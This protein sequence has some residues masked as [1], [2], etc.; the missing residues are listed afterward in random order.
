MVE[1]YS[2]AIRRLDGQRLTV[3]VNEPLN[4]E[5]LQTLYYDYDGAKEIELRFVDPR[6]FT[7][8]QRNFIFALIGDIYSYTGQPT[9]DLT[10]YFK[11]KFNGATGRKISLADNSKNTMSDATQYANLILDF[12]FENGIPFRNGYKILPFN[13]SYFFYKCIVHRVCCSCGK[14]HAHIHHVDVVGMGNNRNKIDNRNRRFMA[15]CGECHQLIHE[16]GYQEFT[17]KRELYA[18]KLDEVALKRLGLHFEEE[19]KTNG[20][21]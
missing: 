15:L 5:R 20:R 8:E 10:E 14:L 11:F 18:V 13:Q 7:A 1:Q 19:E 21:N 17:E 4:L 9:E 6:Q 2:A 3:D 12:I 16:E